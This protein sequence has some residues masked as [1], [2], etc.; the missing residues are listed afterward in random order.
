MYDNRSVDYGDRSGVV[1]QAAFV[2]ACTVHIQANIRNER[3][4]DPL[5]GGG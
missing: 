4:L 2:Q 1:T 3:G 5:A